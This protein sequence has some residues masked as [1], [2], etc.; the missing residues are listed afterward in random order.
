MGQTIRTSRIKQRHT[1]TETHTN[2][3][4]GLYSLAKR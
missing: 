4:V 2:T 3:G 1:Q